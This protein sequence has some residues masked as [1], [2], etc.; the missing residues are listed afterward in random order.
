MIRLSREVRFSVDRD[1]AGRVEFS[2]PVTNSWGGWPSAVGVVPYLRLR[3]TV[4]GQP[5][6]VTGY[7]CNIAILDD[8]LRR[9]AI[10]YTATALRDHGWRMS[11]EDLLG[12]IWE[13]M[14]A[15]APRHA[16]LVALELRPTPTLHYAI[17]RE[18]PAMV[19]LTQQFEFSAAHRLH[20]PQLSSAE[21][22]QMFGK[23]NNPRGHGHNYLLE[24]TLIGQPDE[25][26][27]AVLPLPR[28]EQCVQER[29]IER[30]DHRH[31]NED[32]AEFRDVNPTVENI[33]RAVWGLLVAQVAPARLHC[34]RVWETPKTCAEYAGE[35]EL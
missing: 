14:V 29:V 25:K 27:G 4:A 26:T 21:N 5:D 11:A 15:V 13:Q 1:W 23:C 30:F 34:V 20:C 18:N 6:P 22:R 19:L 17:L 10:P 12:H 24:V 3:A 9:H 32:T 31:L 7:L 8:L 33:A 28:F 35:R 16:P 2:R